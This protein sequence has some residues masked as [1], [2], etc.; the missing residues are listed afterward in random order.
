MK[1]T[2]L[3]LSLLFP[4]AMI[5]QIP[6]T[7]AATNA[8]V[9]VVN[10]QLMNT[11]IQLKAVNKNLARLINLMEKNNNETSKSRKI[12]KEELDAKKTSPDYVMKSTDVSMTMELRDKI[13]EAYRSSKNSIQKWKHLEQDEIQEFAGYTANA[14]LEAKNLFKQCNGIIKTKSIILPEERLKKVSGIN[15]KLEQLLDG[16]IAYNNKLSQINAFREAKLSL[17]NMNKE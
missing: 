5:G 8:S 15:S 10:S 2:L 1:K 16:L 14:I 11:N 7:D 12:L 9:G 17:I 4:M 3:Y 6:V 13:L